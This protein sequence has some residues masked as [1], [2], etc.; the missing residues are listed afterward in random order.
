[1]LFATLAPAT[2]RVRLPGGREALF[3]D[4][5]GFIQKL[6]T[7]LVASF[8]ATLEEIDNSD[9]LLHVVDITHDNV[10][11]Q[12]DAV[13]SVLRELGVVDKPMITALNK[14]DLLP[15]PDEVIDV[16]GREFDD[17][18]PTSAETGCGVQSCWRASKPY[19]TAA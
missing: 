13:G 5:V 3:T 17:A 15:D 9:L 1:M 8:R 12:A 11:E 19:S 2:P 10:M 18:V 7:A 16:L 4:T 6:P 14:V